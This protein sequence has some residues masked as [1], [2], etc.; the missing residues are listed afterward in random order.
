MYRENAKGEFNASFNGCTSIN[1][2]NKDNLLS[3]AK[4]LQHT[5]VLNTDFEQACETA[6]AGDFIFLDSP[7]Y[8]TFDKY[9]S[10][11]FSEAD[12]LRLFKLAE[13]LFAKGC[14]VMLTNSDCDYIRTLYK[15][16]KITQTPVKR[17]IN[18]DAENRVG[19]EVIITN[20]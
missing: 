17:K 19:S 3:F 4:Q 9:T 14:H 7:Y 20:Y 18:C 1:L 8:D 13:R 12:H 2:Y 11:M 5:T 6:S 16:Y 15:D 10:A